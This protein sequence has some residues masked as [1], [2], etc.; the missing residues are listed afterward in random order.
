MST[1]PPRTEWFKTLSFMQQAIL[2]CIWVVYIGGLM[3]LAPTLSNTPGL[4]RIHVEV[5]SGAYQMNS[6]RR[7][8]DHSSDTR[9]YSPIDTHQAQSG[10]IIRPSSSEDSTH[11][12][13]DCP[14]WDV[15]R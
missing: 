11:G 15:F 6:D 8:A 12:H 14:G 10:A 2:V 13:T 4:F 3:V 1:T 9:Q 5:S 7:Y